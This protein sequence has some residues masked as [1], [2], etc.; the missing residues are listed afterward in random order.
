MPTAEGRVQTASAGG[1]SDRH[2]WHRAIAPLG[3]GILKLVVKR[4]ISRP[5]DLA[6][7]LVGLVVGVSLLTAVPLYGDG[8]VEKTLRS[9]LAPSDGRPPLGVSIHFQESSDRPL[10]VERIGRLDAFIRGQAASVVGIPVRSL[11][12]YQ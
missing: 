2:G 7:T 10:G 4:A 8:M 9:A 12:H 5:T 6:F 11:V 1:A 3:L